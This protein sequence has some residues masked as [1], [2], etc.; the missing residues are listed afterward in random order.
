MI[1]LSSWRLRL[2]SKTLEQSKRAAPALERRMVEVVEE[3]GSRQGCVSG[4][5]F[6]DKAREVPATLSS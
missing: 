5:E 6:G 2:L 4:A 3:A 1:C